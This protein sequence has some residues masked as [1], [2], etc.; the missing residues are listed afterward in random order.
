MMEEMST[1]YT[2]YK[3]ARQN[4]NVTL[5][6]KASSYEH[7]LNSMTESNVKLAEEHKAVLSTLKAARRT[8]GTLEQEKQLY[9]ERAT[10]AEVELAKTKVLYQGVDLNVQK[11]CDSLQEQFENKESQLRDLERYG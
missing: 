3:H 1:N 10:K 8:I 5:N 4:V 9:I 6:E 11:R 7:F 2:L